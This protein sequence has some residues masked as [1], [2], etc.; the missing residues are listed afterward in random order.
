VRVVYLLNLA[1]GGGGAEAWEC[2][3]PCDLLI[4]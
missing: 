4:R 1:A 2:F 3:A